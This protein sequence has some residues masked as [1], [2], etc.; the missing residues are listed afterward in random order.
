ML[1]IEISS[2]L[3]LQAVEASHDG[4]VISD[5]QQQGQPIIYAN[6]AFEEMTG[7]SHREIIGRN[8]RFLQGD[9][10]QQAAIKQLRSAIALGHNCEVT[11]RNYK[12]NGELFYNRLSISPVKSDSGQVR[13]YIGV[14]KDVSREILLTKNLK[15]VNS[16]YSQINESLSNESQTDLL[17]G[18]KN[19]RYLDD[20]GTLLF[21]NAR[22]EGWT[23][24]LYMV[25]IDGFRDLNQR[26]GQ[27]LADSG[28]Q[29]CADKITDVFT[30][31]SDIC[32]RL[33]ADRFLILTLCHS[34]DE[35]K[36]QTQ[37]LQQA[38]DS[39]S[40]YAKQQHLNVPVNTTISTARLT[41]T[42][43]DNLEDLI[44]VCV[45]ELA[46]LRQRKAKTNAA[47]GSQIAI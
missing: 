47:A 29:A 26:Y 34:E 11:L 17:T 27:T 24:N 31:D 25:D 3:M 22:R 19:Q 23:L 28:L 20:A 2:D 5:L 32:S 35:H 8:C 18:L 42:S 6:P 12:K 7:Y 44:A 45:T 43:H 13:Y 16:L 40:L 46:Y 15:R 39:I 38:L 36:K 37:R 33:Q 41:P 14:Q 9:D 4:V 1:P 21:T 30:R 10:E